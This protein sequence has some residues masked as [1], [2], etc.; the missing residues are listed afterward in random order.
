MKR[1]DP[2]QERVLNS[3][4]PYAGERPVEGQVVCVLDAR[5]ERR[6]MQLEPHP[7]RAVPAGEIHELTLT[8]DPAAGPGARAERVAYCFCHCFSLSKTAYV[9]FVEIIRGVVVL[10]GDWVTLGPRELG[11]VVGFDCTHFPNHMNIL[12]RS[13]P[14][15]T[16]REPGAT[17]DDPAVLSFE[18]LVGV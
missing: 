15:Q 10:V 13:S 1:I 6:D 9:G 11:R 7:S 17:V 3:D 5:S 12:V 14:T 2:H 16:G 8:D 4:N 18:P